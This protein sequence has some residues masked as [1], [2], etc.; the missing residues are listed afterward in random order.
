[1]CITVFQIVKTAN[2][3]NLGMFLLFVSF[4]LNC[5]VL[6]CVDLNCIPLKKILCLTVSSFLQY[7]SHSGA[8]AVNCVKNI[9]AKNGGVV[10]RFFNELL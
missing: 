8:E 3:V 5:V 6:H 10:S 1:M 9:G 7:F 4:G 2:S